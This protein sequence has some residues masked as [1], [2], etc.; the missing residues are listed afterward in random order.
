MKSEDLPLMWLLRN[1]QATHYETVSIICN[2][3]KAA[4]ENN[5]MKAEFNLRRHSNQ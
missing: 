3:I 1:I 5:V 2:I 4:W